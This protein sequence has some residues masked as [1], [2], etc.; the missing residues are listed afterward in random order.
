[1]V[2]GDL[3]Y[4]FSFRLI[5]YSQLTLFHYHLF[6]GWMAGLGISGSGLKG[7]WL[8]EL[9]GREKEDGDGGAGLAS[10]TYSYEME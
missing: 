7:L 6:A 10:A 9:E 2:F 4:A 3:L 1:M 5:S 8:L